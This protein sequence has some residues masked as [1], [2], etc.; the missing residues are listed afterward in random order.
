MS[1]RVLGRGVEKAMLD[2]LVQEVSNKGGKKLIG[3]YLPT[4][5]NGMVRN[6]YADLGF[7]A[8]D[9]DSSGKSRWV[10]DFESKNKF[11]YFIVSRKGD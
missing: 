5:K 3:E 11:E 2:L 1:C 7:E 6:H 4:A 8:L 9:S 10:L